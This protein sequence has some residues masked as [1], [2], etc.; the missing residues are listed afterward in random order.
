MKNTMIFLLVGICCSCNTNKKLVTRF[1][2]VEPFKEQ[3]MILILNGD[4]TFN[5]QDSTG[6]NQFGFIGR[7]KKKSTS[8]GNYLIFDSII[9]QKTGSNIYATNNSIFSIK[10]GDTAW[11]VNSERIFIDKAPFK[12]SSKKKLSLPEIRYNKLK[13]YYTELLGEKGFAEVF[14]NGKGRKEAKRRLM[15]CTLPDI[16]IISN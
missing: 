7:Y 8:W 15:S 1:Y 14:G 16:R 11:I 4:S 10:N 3:E 13:E 12:L 2:H 6:C 9:L 5:L